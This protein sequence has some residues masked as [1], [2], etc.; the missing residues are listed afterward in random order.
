Y[1]ARDFRSRRWLL[2][3]GHQEV[4]TGG[5]SGNHVFPSSGTHARTGF[6]AKRAN[7][8]PFRSVGCHR[9]CQWWRDLP[10][11]GCPDVCR[12]V[13]GFLPPLGRVRALRRSQVQFKF[14]ETSGWFG[15]APSRTQTSTSRR[16]GMKNIVI[17]GATSKIAQEVARCM[18]RDGKSLLLVGRNGCRLD[19]IC[20]D[21]L[22]RGAGTAATIESDLASVSHH[23]DL[24]ARIRDRMPSFDTILLSY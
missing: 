19:A 3:R 18:A 20:S 6:P 8:G 17:L 9:A 5:V 22:V 24:F 10:G 11:Q 23:Q 7:V 1:P 21:L 16:D 14:L 12:N 4:R 2:P 13:Q 15:S